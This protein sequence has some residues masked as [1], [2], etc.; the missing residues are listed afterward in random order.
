MNAVIIDWWT[1]YQSYNMN[2]CGKLSNDMHSSETVK[3]HALLWNCQMTCTPLKLSNDMHSSETVKWHALLWNCQMTCTLLKLS[4]DMHSSK[5]VKRHALN[6]NCRK[7]CTPLKT[8]AY[9]SLNSAGS[10]LQWNIS[11]LISLLILQNTF[12]VIKQMVTLSF[13]FFSSF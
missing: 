12:P 3:W 1:K 13:V 11:L 10:G 9:K 5:T 4:N 6:W 8:T 7:A 2:S